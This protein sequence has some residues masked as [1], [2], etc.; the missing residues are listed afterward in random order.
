VRK[1]RFSR[2][3]FGAGDVY[4]GLCG[5]IDQH[6][7]GNNVESGVTG[8]GIQTGMHIL[9]AVRSMEHPFIAQG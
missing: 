1:G 2:F 8:I 9:A 7:T 3:R 6:L 4:S 5:T